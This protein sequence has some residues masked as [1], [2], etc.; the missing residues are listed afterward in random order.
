M[1]LRALLV[2]ALLLAA[3]TTGWLAWNKRQHATA[4][5]AQSRADYVLYDFQ[6]VALDADGKE[7]M[8]LRAPHLARNGQD[9]TLDIQTPLFLMPDGDGKHWQLA[10]ATGWVSADGNEMRLRGGVR[11]DSPADSTIAPTTFRPVTPS[12]CSRAAISPAP[13]MPWR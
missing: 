12:A 7:S 6:I 9:E 11:G 8:T 13:T 4:A 3:V 2:G 10:A 5:G 1:N